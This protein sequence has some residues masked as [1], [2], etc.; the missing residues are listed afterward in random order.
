MKETLKIFGFNL[1][2]VSFILVVFD[3]FNILNISSVLNTNYLFFAGCLFGTISYLIYSENEKR[4]DNFIK[5]LFLFNIVVLTSHQFFNFLNS[6][7]TKFVFFTISFGFITFY[8][9]KNRIETGLR[10]EKIKEIKFEERRKNDFSSRFSNINNIPVLGS[11]IRWIYSLGFLYFFALVGTILFGLLLRI[12]N[13]GGLYP[14]VDEFYNLVSAKR[15]ALDGY[16]MTYDQGSLLSYLLGFMIKLGLT[17]L[18]YLRIITVIFGVLNIFLIFLLA[19]KISKSVGII[20]AILF[21]ILPLA[22]GISR[23]IRYYE[24]YLSFI[25]IFMLVLIKSLKDRNNKKFLLLLLGLPIL[26][27]IMMGRIELLILLYLLGISF[28]FIFGHENLFRLNKI[29]LYIIFGSFL[30]LCTYLIYRVLWL[31]KDI[32]FQPNYLFVLFDPS[33]SC[34]W[35]VSWFTCTPSNIFLILFIFLVPIFFLNKNKILEISYIWF[36]LLIVL[37]TFFVN[38][39]FAPRY[40]YYFIVFYV[41]IFAYGISLFFKVFYTKI[42]FCKIFYIILI[43]IF[44]ISIFSPLNAINGVNLDDTERFSISSLGHLKLNLLFDFID[45]RGF[46]GGDVLITDYPYIFLYYY[47]YDFITDPHKDLL[48]SVSVDSYTKKINYDYAKNLYNYNETD[49]DS[50]TYPWAINIINEKDSG[51]IIFDKRKVSNFWNDNLSFPYKI[52]DKVVYDLG[53]VW[54]GYLTFRV[55]KW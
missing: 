8:T 22:I 21:S 42:K 14:H 1:F 27:Y 37:L 4:F 43:I 15:F 32:I 25:L 44:I 28:Y 40:M 46:N 12:W 20:S 36:S 30:I 16:F 13:L 26:Y 17:E 6:Y 54:V 45:N 55:Y 18:V 51:W 53:D 31:Y 10:D 48:N 52:G 7:L 50:N 38:F 39:S 33:N 49:F 2:L 24:I 34:W 35:R 41:M 9:E 19:K 11:S 3:S 29:K 47:D 23:F 5:Y